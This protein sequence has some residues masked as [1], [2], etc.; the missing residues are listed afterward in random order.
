MYAL[1]SSEL[2]ERFDLFQ[3]KPV[4]IGPKRL[5]YRLPTRQDC[6]SHDQMTTQRETA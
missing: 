5:R 3:Q 6:P 1:K 2:T 4:L